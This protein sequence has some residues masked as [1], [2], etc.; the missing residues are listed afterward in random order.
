MTIKERLNKLRDKIISSE[1][2]DDT[3]L[4]NEVN[5]H[6]FDYDVADEYIVREYVNRLTESYPGQICNINIHDIIIGILSEKN[7]LDKVFEFE[8]KKGTDFAATAVMRVLGI[9]KK[10]GPLMNEIIKQVEPEKIVFITG[11]GES[12][13]IIRA[14]T[15]LANMQSVVTDNPVILFY[16]GEYDGHS[17]KLFNK[18]EATNYYRAFKLVER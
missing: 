2:L 6:I 10:N 12:Y 8:E 3:G 17:L 14:H 5:Y 11:I 13:R 7:Y 18:F 9:E 4:G 16:P 15:L 1:L